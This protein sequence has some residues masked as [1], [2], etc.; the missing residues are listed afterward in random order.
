MGTRSLAKQWKE[1]L[2]PTIHRA[3]IDAEPPLGEP[4]DDVRI[5]QPIADIPANGQGD[6]VIRKAIPRER[7]D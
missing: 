4:L 7:A 3:A 1:P 6:Q 5:A 2:D